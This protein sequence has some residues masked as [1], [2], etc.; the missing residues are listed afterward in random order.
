MSEPLRVLVVDDNVDAAET[1]S[2]LLDLVG[3]DTRTEYDGRVALETARAFK[4][5]ACVLDIHMPGLDGCR[6]ARALRAEFDGE[7][8]LVAVTGVTGG[9]YD[10]RMAGAGFDARFAKPADPERIVAAMAGAR[11]PG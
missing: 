10:E 7:L 3:C 8:R 5:G 9:D 4:P 2:A 1:L 11:N 6:L